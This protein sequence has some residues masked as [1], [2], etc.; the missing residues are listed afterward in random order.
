M[1]YLR[2]SLLSRSSKSLNFLF[3]EYHMYMKPVKHDIRRIIFEALA[4]VAFLG[5]C[6]MYL[7]REH[8]V[9]VS[10]DEYLST[11][12]IEKYGLSTDK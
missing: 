10:V 5:F 9:K 12:D 1:Y 7:T 11:N 2:E 6:F 3:S 4:L 8:F